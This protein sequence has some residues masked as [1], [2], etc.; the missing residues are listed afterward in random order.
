MT[1]TE[2]PSNSFEIIEIDTVGFLRI[3]NGYR[4]ILT[5][6][7][8]LTKYI[9]AYPIEMKDAKTIA[10]TLVEQF[11]LKCGCFKTLKSDRG[12]EFKN[13]LLQDV[14]NLLNIN[15]KFSAPYHHQTI[16]SLERN[17]RV[18]N[19]SL[20]NFVDDYEWDKWIPY[21]TFAYNTTPHVDTDYS[22]YELI[23][24]KLATLPNTLYENK[25]KIYNLENYSNELKLRLNKSITNAKGSWVWHS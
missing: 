11:V 1:I 3:S 5:M 17:H 13:E 19:E 22:P 12:T 25:E 7:C 24:G 10:K 8:N 16:G 9:V 6:Q 21:Y 2:N 20:L 14:C 23:Y 15:Q 18:L 4:Y